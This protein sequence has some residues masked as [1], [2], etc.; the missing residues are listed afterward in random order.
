M[1]KAAVRID[2]VI[3]KIIF[4]LQVLFCIYLNMHYQGFSFKSWSLLDAER[5]LLLYE[6]LHFQELM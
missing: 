2:D 3:P 4:L 6:K 5:G 1:Q